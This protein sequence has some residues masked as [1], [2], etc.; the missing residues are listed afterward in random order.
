LSA[1]RAEQ[2]FT[3][4]P[5]R[6][7]EASLVKA[8]EEHG[9]G[10]PSTYAS[11]IS[12]LQIAN[13]S[14]WKPALR[15]DRHRQDRLPLPHAS[16]PSL[17]GVRLHR[18]RWKTSCDAVSR[19]EEDWTTPLEVLEALHPPGRED[20][21]DRSRASR[22]NQARELVFHRRGEAVLHVAMEVMREEAQTILPMSVGT[23]RRLSI[24]TYSRSAASR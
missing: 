9:I 6:Y 11:I 2:H 20:R 10:R 13:T 23:K 19:G 22:L 14:K 8:L 12:T 5:P 21:E 24:S 17:R 15:A 7:S 1:L 18:G 16:L 4:P 3:E